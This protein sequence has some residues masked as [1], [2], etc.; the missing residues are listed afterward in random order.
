[1]TIETATSAWISGLQT[2]INNAIDTL[3]EVATS[4]TF[5]PG[6]ISI[7]SLPTW[8][9][10]ASALSSAELAKINE[11]PELTVTTPTTLPDLSAYTTTV[12]NEASWGD[13]KTLLGQFNTTILGANAIDTAIG[14]L[15]GDTANRTQNAIYAADLERKQQTL[16][17]LFSAASASAGS[18]GFNYPNSMVTA[19]KLDAQQKY[20]FDKEQTARKLIE[21]I[22][23][24]AKQQL[25]YTVDGSIAAHNSDVEFNTKFATV[26]MSQY[27]DQLQLIFDQYKTKIDGIIKQHELYLKEFEVVSGALN[28]AQ[29]SYNS[30]AVGLNQV[31]LEAGA[32]KAGY[33]MQA[34][35][36]A[37]KALSAQAAS[38]NQTVLNVISGAQ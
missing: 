19:L 24:W 12:W 20:Q 25:K 3:N 4:W 16:R 28:T 11:Y 27:K 29:N 5:S 9:A 34:A 15:V 10:S 7:T 38:F 17:D 2:S 26:L 13:L 37:A 1:M 18:R 32:K 33:Q 23:D 6:S 21:Q 22:F 31:S 35:S 8:Y 30:S 36:E 14:V